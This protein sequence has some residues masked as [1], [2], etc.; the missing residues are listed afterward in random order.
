MT[1]NEDNTVVIN[2]IATDI[3]SSTLNVMVVSQPTNGSITIKA[4]GSFSYTPTANF[5]GTDSFTYKVNDGELDSDLATV[6][7][8]VI[9]VNDVPI[10]NP[11]TLAVSEDGRLILNLLSQGSDIDGDSLT[12]TRVGQPQHGV[13]EQD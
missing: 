4:D 1:T 8:T 12:I 5:N 11:V 10:V 6:S 7:I 13:I 9:P 2:L 3:D